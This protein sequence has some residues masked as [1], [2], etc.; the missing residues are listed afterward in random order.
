MGHSRVSIAFRVYL[1]GP[2]GIA[3]FS[4]EITAGEDEA[5]MAAD[6]RPIVA[7]EHIVAD[8]TEHLRRVLAYEVEHLEPF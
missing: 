5:V 7:L 2:S 3:G 4:T 8:A 1:D 6:A